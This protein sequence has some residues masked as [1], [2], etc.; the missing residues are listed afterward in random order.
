MGIPDDIVRSVFMTP[1]R[2]VQAAVDAALAELG[3]AARV[4]I[5]PD[6]GAVVPVLTP[7]A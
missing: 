7:P 6:A 5:I 2:S 3:S 4:Y 1:F